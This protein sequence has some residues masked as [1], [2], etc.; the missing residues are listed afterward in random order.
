M[1]GTESSPPG[2]PVPVVDAIRAAI[3]DGE[4]VPNQRLVEADLSERFGASRT[5]VRTALVQ[6]ASEGLVERVQ[7]RGARVRAV[8]LEEAIEITEVRMALEG[9]CA[10]KAAERLTD[11][12]R[13]RLREIG[14]AMRAAVAGGD[15]LGYSELNQRLHG[16][17]LELSGQSTAAGILERL[18]GQSV[19]HQFRL[20]MHP[21]RPAVS[22]PQHLEIIEAL[23]AGDAEAAEAAMRRHIRSV[24]ETLPEVD[25]TRTRRFDAI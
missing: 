10:A 18:R 23:C 9:L 7:N 15:L 24:I 4:F 6:L 11:A 21:G 2:E 14:D 19:R 22:L 20:A 16:L 8:S 13:D 17:V 12:D 1:T 3:A 5:T 25:A